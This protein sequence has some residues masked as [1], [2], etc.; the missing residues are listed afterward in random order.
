MHSNLY[1]MKQT[2]EI[3]MDLRWVATPLLLSTP[4]RQLLR[5]SD[6][7]TWSKITAILV[8]TSFY[9]CVVESVL[10]FC[11]LPMLNSNYTA[12]ERKELQQVVE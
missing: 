8:L 1:N 12:V 3:I 2:K 10:T 4:E 5:W 6:N 11:S 9:R 7:H